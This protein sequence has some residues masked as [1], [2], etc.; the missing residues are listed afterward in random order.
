MAQYSTYLGNAY[1]NQY[2]TYIHA[3]D[4][5]SGLPIWQAP[6][7]LNSY[8]SMSVIDANIDV[9]GHI[10]IVG[11]VDNAIPSVSSL[12]VTI[13][14]VCGNGVYDG[15]VITLDSN[16]NR[17]WQACQGTGGY[18]QSPAVSSDITGAV[19]VGG[20]VTGSFNGASYVPSTQ[21]YADPFI[22]KYDKFGNVI[23][24]RIFPTTDG[25]FVHRLVVDNIGGLFLGLVPFQY[26]YQTSTYFTPS[27]WAG[28]F[29]SQA[30][31]YFSLWK[32]D[33]NS[34]LQWAQGGFTYGIPYR[35]SI[36]NT[37]LLTFSGTIGSSNTLHG[38]QTSGGSF[39]G[40]IDQ[41]V[42]VY[43]CSCGNLASLVQQMTT[44]LNIVPQ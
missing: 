31:E 6:Q 29:Y 27:N 42:L 38:L 21:G 44:L 23:W 34:A 43:N 10:H 41:Q 4:A 1:H 20:S 12:G 14:Q 11:I 32:T 33:T 39:D 25:Y 40:Y 7:Y 28:G 37:G 19:F 2:Q 26:N 16:G 8:S 30:N 36:D 15:F 17:L 9:F 13:P 18:D 3:F 24:T 22:V 5:G 35:M